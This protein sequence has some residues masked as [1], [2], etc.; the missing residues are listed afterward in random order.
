MSSQKYYFDKPAVRVQLSRVRFPKICPVCGAPATIL[1]RITL[2][3][4]GSRYL[5]RSW[6]PY[7]SPYARI[8]S[9]LPD[10]KHRVLPIYV[11]EKHHYSDEGA[12]RYQS[13]CFITDGFAM[14]FFF[15]GLLFIGDAFYRGRPLPFWSVVFSI[16]FALSLSLTWFAFRPN[17]IQR[18]VQIVGFDPGMQNILLVF[19]NELYRE[20]VIQDN[21]MTT[22]L[23]S[24]IVRHKG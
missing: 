8:R 20:A 11:C 16:F 4:R 13:C 1:S 18:A 22:E 23:V 24:W 10:P 14:A 7:Y 3:E 21:P 9:Q 17:A 6:D 15:F 5:N 19:D 12:D 2:T